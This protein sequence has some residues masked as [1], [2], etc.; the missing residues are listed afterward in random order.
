MDS[1]M[2]FNQVNRGR[3]SSYNRRGNQFVIKDN[4]RPRGQ[5]GGGIT[6]P[7]QALLQRSVEGHKTS[8]NSDYSIKQILAKI[9]NCKNFLELEKFYN[10][11]EIINSNSIYASIFFGQLASV[12]VDNNGDNDRVKFLSKFQEFTIN[13]L[14]SEFNKKSLSNLINNGLQLWVNG[15]A[16]VKKIALEI[17]NSVLTESNQ[18]KRM[19][20]LQ[21]TILPNLANNVIKLLK[22]QL[23]EELLLLSL[24]KKVFK[25]AADLKSFKNFNF[26]DLSILINA[27]TNALKCASY[28]PDKKLDNLKVMA[29]N[30]LN[31]AFQSLITQTSDPALKLDME[32][33]PGLINGAL[34]FLEYGAQFHIDEIKKQSLE[35]L[36]KLFH[37][38]CSA[39]EEE[40]KYFMPRQLANLANVVLKLLE[41][42]EQIEEVCMG[43]EK[44]DVLKLI[45]NEVKARGPLEKFSLQSLS[46]LINDAVRLLKY[47]ERNKGPEK[48]N[49]EENTIWGVIDQILARFYLYFKKNVNF[50]WQ[51]LSFLTSD[52]IWL[53]RYLERKELYW[54]TSGIILNVLDQAFNVID[55]KILKNF[56]SRELSAL[57]HSGTRLLEYEGE[58][59][60]KN[61]LKAIGLIFKAID[62]ADN[63]NH[64][65]SRDLSIL[66][67]VGIT[68]IESNKQEWVKV[69][70][71][72]FN[73][74]KDRGDLDKFNFQDLWILANAGLRLLKWKHRGNVP[75]EKEVLALF[76]QILNAVN[77][78]KLLKNFHIKALSDLANAGIKI[79]EHYPKD[80]AILPIVNQLFEE[81]NNQKEPKNKDQDECLI[82]EQSLLNTSYLSHFPQNGNLTE[83]EVQ[84]ICNMAWVFSALGKIKYIESWIMSAFQIFNDKEIEFIDS[85]AANQLYQV[86][87]SKALRE[88][89]WNGS[90]VADFLF[91]EEYLSE[92][93]RQR[94]FKLMM[95]RWN[96]ASNEVTLE[97]LTNVEERMKA[98]LGEKELIKGS[99]VWAFMA[100]FSFIDNGKRGLVKV[101]GPTEFKEDEENRNY[102]LSHQFEVELLTQ[103]GYRV[104]DIDWRDVRD[105]KGFFQESL[106]RP[107]LPSKSQIRYRPRKFYQ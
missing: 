62:T 37:T 49:L 72:I 7:N 94:I 83:K 11:N 101:N 95:E 78:N 1:H 50:D 38:V 16:E 47:G 107:T 6:I 84:E 56:K 89:N 45:F 48:L 10:Q 41:Y 18:P 5:N 87:L 105:G 66:A 60:Q 55:E 82:H 51:T 96:N 40:L 25:E 29:L 77:Q 43:Q 42:E 68:L 46:N 90:V 30:I 17:I 36:E 69:L 76:I 39:D 57:L 88:K 58:G 15:N 99:V 75:W 97:L 22:N 53:L 32:F 79:L 70:I 33:L 102:T 73:S 59:L 20:R 106:E 19:E 98:L 13:S 85:E 21:L 9:K 100:D 71:K 64:F 35:I 74:V 61:A 8:G 24:V 26:K 12:F 80:Q 4:T 67:N 3:A 52:G 23:G 81:I 14:L 91:S 92:P 27:G 31:K 104:I 63:L 54:A 93:L 65:N 2:Y 86:F 103:M 34:K 44:W 28:A